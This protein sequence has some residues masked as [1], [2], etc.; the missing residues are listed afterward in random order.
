[1]HLPAPPVKY[2]Q[3]N[4]AQTRFSIEQELQRLAQ[5]LLQA[6]QTIAEHEARLT[7]GGL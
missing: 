1:M 6:Q 4:E 2:A 5:L 7:A 3:D